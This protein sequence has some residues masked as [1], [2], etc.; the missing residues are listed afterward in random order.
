[1]DLHGRMISAPTT[2]YQ[3]KFYIVG[4]AFG[5]PLSKLCRGG[6]PHPPKAASKFETLER[7]GRRSLQKQNF[8]RD[9]VVGTNSVRPKRLFQ[10]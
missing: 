1:M 8:K 10:I 5:G 6:C 4:T 2:L 7:R 3:F 9:T